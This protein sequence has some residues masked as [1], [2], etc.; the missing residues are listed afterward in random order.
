MRKLLITIALLVAGLAS[1]AATAA[2][3]ASVAVPNKPNVLTVDYACGRG[4]HLSPRGFCRPNRWAPP[5]SYYGWDRGY[6]WGRPYREW[7]EYRR[8][9]RWD[10]DWR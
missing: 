1:G 2:P 8:D 3:V 5:P 10:R 7:R 6:G 9:D 4:Y